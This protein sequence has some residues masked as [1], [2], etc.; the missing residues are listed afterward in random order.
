MHALFLYLRYTL[1]LLRKSP[2][3][4]ITAVLILAFGIGVNTAIFS[5]IDAAMLKPLPFPDPDRLV[6]VCTPYQKEWTMW[7]NYPDYLD[8]SSTQHSFESLSVVSVPQ[9]LDLGGTNEAQQVRVFF[10]S[11]G[12]AKVGGLPIKLGRW[13]NEGEDVPHGPLVAVLSEPFWRSHFQADPNI[14]GKNIILSG[15]SF[16][17]VGVA[18]MQPSTCGPPVAQVYVPTNALLTVMNWSINDRSG[19]YVDCLGRLKKGVT[20]AQA[21]AELETLHNNLI[22][23]YPDQDAGYGLLIVPLSDR[24]VVFYSQTIWLLG[25]AAVCLLLISC[26][27]VANLLYARAVERRQ[28]MSI[29]SA[30]GGTRSRLLG[31][32]L[33][34][35]AFLSVL[36][37][38]GGIAIAVLAVGIIRELAPPDLYRLDEVGIDFR[39]LLFVTGATMFVSLVSGLLP[40]LSLSKTDVPSM[41]KAEGGRTNTAGRERQKTQAFLVIGQVA[42]ACVLLIGTGLLTRSFLAAE[43][44]PLGFNPHQILTAQITLTSAKYTFDAAKERAFFDEILQKFVSCREWRPRA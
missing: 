43:S 44:V 26:A 40:S 4:T 36:G 39:A 30:L 7:M 24:V 17:I 42:V 28:E 27:N 1:R 3:F 25:A 11:P 41:L 23:R 10:V 19:H 15:W 29:R 8:L 16:Q 34:E 35:T 38:A 2:G 32:S 21:Q 22:A 33:L 14:V 31:Q 9:T 12:L 6:E 5:L 37:A 18:P 20:I 13:L